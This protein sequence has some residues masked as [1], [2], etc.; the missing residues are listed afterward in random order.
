MK[1]EKSSYQQI[2]KATSLFG[3]VQVFN[4]VIAIIR[5]KAIAILLG[6]TG[7]GIVALLT[8]TTDL[9]SSLTN[10]GL[11]TSAVKDISE[12]NESGNQDR[13][14]K[15]AAVLRRLVWVTGLLGAG[16]TLI[17]STWLSEF[18][19]GNKDYTWSFI[20]LS[21]T[22]LLSQLA[23]GQ[24]VILQGMR[25]LKY[26][27]FSNII[28][29]VLSLVITLPLYYFYGL[30]GIVPALIIMGFASF[31]IAV[32]F[33][34]KVKIPK[35]AVTKEVVIKEGKGMLKLGFMLSL[36]GLIST[37]VAYLMRIYISNIGSVDDVGLYSAGFSIIGT[38]VGLVFTAMSTDYYP[39]LC[40]VSNDNSK[41]NTL[42]NQQGEIAVL[43]L[44]PIIL[45]FIVFIPYI[46]Q[47]LYSS[48][49]LPINDMIIWAAFAMFFKAGSW[50]MGFQFLAKGNSKL[51]FLNELIVNVLMLISN[52]IGYHY[53][54][55]TGLG[56]S[57]LL[58]YV[59]YTVQLFF[60]TKH[61]YDFSIHANFLKT[62]ILAIAVCAVCLA[63]TLNT[64]S[65][66]KYSIGSLLIVGASI[67]T[68]YQLNHKTGILS[69]IKWRK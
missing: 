15:V 5:S 10:L 9:I 52:I 17:L 55:L 53:F 51:F 11:G 16:L 8:S 47:L 46:V 4:I 69:K 38:Y 32:Y 22:L 68:I 65:L 21:I 19:F 56:Y 24:N 33:V 1:E 13:I 43:I 39:R 14:A 36:S 60:F 18:T 40:G 26:L 63:I 29:A 27:A 37:L 30:D 35:T 61:Y 54:G 12:A 20:L 6:P 7:M 25:R 57:F 49:F 41:R 62:F 45:V 2:V 44:F 34:K 66:I 42:V 58:T 48:K 67:F 28:G 64:S 31:S 59:I 50:V 3:G 23:S